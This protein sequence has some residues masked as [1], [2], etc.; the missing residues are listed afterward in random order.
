MHQIFSRTMKFDGLAAATRLRKKSK[1]FWSRKTQTVKEEEEPN[2]KHFFRLINVI[3]I[4]PDE[5]VRSYGC[6]VILYF[7]FLLTNCLISFKLIYALFFVGIFEGK[8]LNFHFWGNGA[9]RSIFQ[10]FLAN[11]EVLRIYFRWDLLRRNLGWDFFGL[12]R[13]AISL[14]DF[15]NVNVIIPNSLIAT[16]P[17][18]IAEFLN[19]LLMV[20]Q[21]LLLILGVTIPLR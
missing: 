8:Q 4:L 2:Q 14:Y 9:L 21:C 3:E 6:F 5:I 11:S 15:L 10:L 19:L 20:H 18:G 17:H 12:T 13:A 1:S 7:D 16:H